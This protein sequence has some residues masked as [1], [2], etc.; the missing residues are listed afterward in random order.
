VDSLGHAG[1]SEAESE[2]RQ[3]GRIR[4]EIR[5]LKANEGVADE[6][7]VWCEVKTS[8]FKAI[9]R[10]FHAKNFWPTEVTGKDLQQEKVYES[11][12]AEIW[13]TASRRGKWFWTPS[14]HP[15][16]GVDV[17]TSQYQILSVFLGLPELEAA[18]QKRSLKDVFTERA[19]TRDASRGDRFHLPKGFKSEDSRLTSSIKQ[20]LLT[21]GYGAEPHNIARALRLSPE[22]Y[23]PGL[24][25]GNNI[26]ALL[27]GDALLAEIFNTWKPACR[28]LARRA[29]KYE[30][31]ILTDPFDRAKVRW[32]PVRVDD[33]ACA[34]DGDTVKIRANLPV[35]AQRA[36]G[37]SGVEWVP[38]VANP[39]GNYPIDRAELGRMVG[40]CIVHML[41]SLFAGIVVENL[42][43]LG[44][45]NVVSIHDSWLIPEDAQ[46]ALRKAVDAAGEPWL[47]A[48]QPV[49]DDLVRYLGSTKYGD[50]T[51]EKRDIWKRRVKAKKWP[52]FRVEAQII[53]E[54]RPLNVRKV[55][56]T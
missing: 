5:A 1:N 43:A 42:N 11:E 55:S 45:H 10:R 3:Y 32:N 54:S 8:I 28:E 17:S 47:R 22:E 4:E 50:W 48:L 49:Y 27:A 44:V 35:M 23:G 15:L 18:L 24:G 33:T 7:E 52:I 6:P 20:A 2:R 56:R 53:F 36:K 26:Q 9:N 34:G 12:H 29:D 21:F 38:A 30:G 13:A 16:V 40:P 31:L 51:R 41:D 46:P 14:R 19:R 25:D 37:R 39:A